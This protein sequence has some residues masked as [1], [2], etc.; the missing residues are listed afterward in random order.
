[1]KQI[2]LILL[3]FLLLTVGFAVRQPIVAETVA[4]SVDTLVDRKSAIPPEV[5]EGAIV[6][7]VESDAMAHAKIGICVTDLRTGEAVAVYNPDRKFVPASVTKLVTSATAL[8]YLSEAFKFRT[9]V[10][11]SGEVDGDGVLDGDLIVEGGMDP[12]LGSRYFEE[13][14]NFL[15]TL[16]EILRL[17]G[18]RTVR[19][20]VKTEETV[21]TLRQAV[22]GN[23]ENADVTKYYGAGVYSL[24]YND[25]LFSLIVDTSGKRAVVVDTIP[26]ILSIDVDNAM[27]IGSSRSGRSYPKLSRTKYSDRLSLGGT[28]RR[29]EDP[30]EVVS[31]MPHP[32]EA[33]VADIKETL[34]SEGIEVLGQKVKADG[35]DSFQLLSYESPA[36]PDILNSL[37]CRSDNMY[38]EAVLRILGQHCK[39]APTREAGVEAVE[40]VLGQWNVDTG[41][42]ALY[43]GSGLGRA[44]RMSPRFLS[45]LLRA[46]ARDWQCGE[47]FP[48]LLP[49]AGE[50][51]TVQSLL[52]ETPL[53]GSIALKSGSMNGV[54]CYAGY[55]PAVRPKYAVSLMVNGYRCNA[56]NL[57]ESIER[58]FVGMFGACQE[59]SA[60]KTMAVEYENDA[61]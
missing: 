44:N 56:E 6:E 49:V 38:A 47:L 37:L 43:D 57:K 8:K 26:H 20:D 14:E 5:L 4:E 30:I 18:I 13:H 22:P 50:Q 54:K 25:N 19:G 28:M 40:E 32:A 12:T 15:S 48:S 17:W 29:M 58:L 21:K 55:Y 24:N 10:K 53:S 60:P 42:L 16:V 51:G 2:K 7:F 59:S 33:L 46:A 35:K 23:W 34:E 27:R 9:R 39:G 36:L 31:P 11:Y 45:G 3:V 61:L 41:G 1:M 52:K